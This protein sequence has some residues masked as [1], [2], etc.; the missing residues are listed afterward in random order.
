MKVEIK[1]IFE[2]KG[3]FRYE[4]DTFEEIV[5]IVEDNY[6][7]LAEIASNGDSLNLYKDYN[8]KYFPKAT[9][10][11]CIAGNWRYYELYTEITEIL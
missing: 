10:S 8:N 6:K 9:I 11:A 1:Y 4:R 2:T 3:G 5:Q 7:A